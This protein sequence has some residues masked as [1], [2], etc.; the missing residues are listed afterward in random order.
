[1]RNATWRPTSRRFTRSAAR[2]TVPACTTVRAFPSSSPRCIRATLARGYDI[3][4][5]VDA[6]EADRLDLSLDLF[7]RLASEPALEGW[8]GLGF[9]VQAYQKRARSV[10]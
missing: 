3:G 7:E 6:E 10:I 2:R 9:V 4:L 5:N 8:S 1:M